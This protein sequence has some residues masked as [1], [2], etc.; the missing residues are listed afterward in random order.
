MPTPLLPIGDT[1]IWD[2][3]LAM[4]NVHHFTNNPVEILKVVRGHEGLSKSPSGGTIG[5]GLTKIH[6]NADRT[7]IVTSLD[8]AIEFHGARGKDH[9]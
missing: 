6:P 5:G 2:P 7:T 1:A 9:S 3:R 4:M 8:D